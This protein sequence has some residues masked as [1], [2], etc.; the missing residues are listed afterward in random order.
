M[1]PP[2]VRQY[3]G[4]DCLGEFVFRQ[5]AAFARK[6]PHLSVAVNLSPAQFSHCDDLAKTMIEIALEEQ[7]N[8]IQIEF[9]VT[10]KR[11]HGHR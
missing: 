8:P 9:E 11:F 6:H 1:D 2:T 10:E 4:V 7:V 5:S 3:S